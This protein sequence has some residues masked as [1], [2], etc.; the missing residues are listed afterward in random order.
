M[1]RNNLSQIL[2]NK[3]IV[4]AYAVIVALVVISNMTG[5]T[6]SCDTVNYLIVGIVFLYPIIL[7]TSGLKLK[8]VD[9]LKLS[10]GIMVFVVLFILLAQPAMLIFGFLHIERKRVQIWKVDN[11]KIELTSQLGWAGP[12]SY[13][14]IL[15]RNLVLNLLEQR[16]GHSYPGAMVDSCMVDFVK[17]NSD[18][19]IY[20]FDECNL[21]VKKIKQ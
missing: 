19:P 17:F 15:K 7:F 3:K 9:Y 12:P 2:K 5:I 11:Y 13:H 10:L 4:T 18:D 16:I 20:R 21:E 8:E 6:F 1:T 14:Y